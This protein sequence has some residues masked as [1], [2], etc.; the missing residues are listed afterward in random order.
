MYFASGLGEL[1]GVIMANNV[2]GGDATGAERAAVDPRTLDFIE[3]ISYY[4]HFAP[5][6]P[7]N[8][9]SHK[10]DH[11]ESDASCFESWALPDFIKTGPAR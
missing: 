11:H 5:P 1:E 9:N 6:A 4:E 8:D 2:K 7:V 3:R 10:P